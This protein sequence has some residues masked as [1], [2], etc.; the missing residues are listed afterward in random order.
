MTER[1]KHTPGPWIYYTGSLR[2]D[3]PVII[4]EIQDLDGGAIVKWAGFD[5]VLQRKRVIEADARLIAAAPELLWALK[6]ARDWLS[7]EDPNWEPRKVVDA[8][9]AKAEGK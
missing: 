2:A 5:G 4:H 7:D 1:A 9:I 6:V 8:A 3:F